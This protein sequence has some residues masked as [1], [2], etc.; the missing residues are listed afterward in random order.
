MIHEGAQMKLKVKRNAAML[1][2][3]MLFASTA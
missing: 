2:A 1:A 3:G